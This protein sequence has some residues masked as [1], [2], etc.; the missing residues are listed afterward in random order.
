MRP[1]GCRATS[2]TTRTVYQH[3]LRP[4]ITKGADLLDEV[5]GKLA[6]EPELEAQWLWI[7]L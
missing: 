2:L 5:F 3:Q 6:E 4:V 7:W 1:L